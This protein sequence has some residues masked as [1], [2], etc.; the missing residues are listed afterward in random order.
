MTK[1]SDP[2]P[3]LLCRRNPAG[4]IEAVAPRGVLLN[5]VVW[6]RNAEG[7]VEAHTRQAI[8]AQEAQ[9]DG[10]EAV[11][12]T[13]AEVAAFMGEVS[14]QANPL[15]QTD[16]GVVRVLEDL[17]DVLINRGLIQFTDLPEAAQAK[18]LERRQT[19]ATLT[20]RLE[21]YPFD[22]GNDQL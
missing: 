22:T 7:H 17:V 4:H 12:P 1:M 20:N 10:W 19:R 15:R 8:T 2:A 9:E 11:A 14:N 13:D 6:S 18:L 3:T 5:T 21:L 16:A